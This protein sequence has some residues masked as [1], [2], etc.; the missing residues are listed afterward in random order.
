MKP[1][2]DQG[3]V[4]ARL[5]VYGVMGLKVADMSIAPKNVGTVGIGFAIIDVWSNCPHRIRTRRHSSLERRLR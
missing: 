1:E 3:V 2:S 5:N 4:D